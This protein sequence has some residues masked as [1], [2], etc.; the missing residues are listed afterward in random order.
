MNRLHLRHSWIVVIAC[1]W[2][3]TGHAAAAAPAPTPLPPGGVWSQIGAVTAPGGPS[4]RDNYGRRLQLEGADLVAKCGGGARPL[5]AAGTPCV[6]PASGGQP[7]FVLSPTAGDPGRRFTAADAASLAQ[8]GFS[9]VRLGIVWQGLEPGP[10]GAGPNEARYCAPHRAGTRFTSLGRAD[11]YS[12]SV[13]QAYL[14]RTDTIVNMLQ[15]AGL[16]V[17]I[18]MHQDAYGSAFSDHR[19]ILPWNGEGAP[20][21]ATCTD[22][23]AFLGR[24][25]WGQA[26][27]AVAVE[28]AIRH[29]WHNDVRGDLQ[30][31]FARVWQAVA[32]HYRDNPDVIGYEVFNEPTDLSTPDFSRELQCAYAGRALSPRSCARGG[33][34]PLSGGLIGAIEAADPTHLVFFE[35]TI[36]P[37]VLDA[38]VAGITER[39]RFPRLVLAF[40]VYGTPPPGV[41]GCPGRVCLRSEREAMNHFLSERNHIR[42]LQPGGP[43]MIMDEFGGGPSIPDIA[44]VAELARERAL[45]WSYW[46]ALQLHDPTGAPGENLLNDRTGIPWPEKARALAGPYAL[47]TAGRPGP[48]F[49]EPSTRS[50][51][52][53]YTVDPAVT[54]PTEIV[55]PP[56]TY[57]DGYHVVVHGAIVMSAPDAP[58]LALSPLPGSQQVRVSVA[59]GG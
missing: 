54:E 1:G 36:S 30:G 29:F 26:Y 34:Q 35:P 9:V 27:G 39:L 59:P 28:A 46:S 49:F 56:Y 53:R 33:V 57:P 22:G 51:T 3:L 7:A 52:Y 17:I 20:P 18:D 32:T 40:H 12:A 58:E 5:K 23:H 37:S 42:T 8:L 15:A 41:F 14:A 24:S 47:A 21:W 13:V 2:A 55:V 43:A 6:G 16:R 44:Q 4:L 25:Y 10:P 31:Q 38:N 11:P 50:F 45:S 19:G 48:A